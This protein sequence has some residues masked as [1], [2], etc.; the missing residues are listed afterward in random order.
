[1]HL[2]QTLNYYNEFLTEKFGSFARSESIKELIRLEAK[3]I[4]TETAKKQK[5]NTWQIPITVK[6]HENGTYTVMP[7][8][9]NQVLI[10]DFDK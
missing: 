2:A 7:E 6:F 9:E 5:T 1:M 4:Q 3:R 10:I 8:N